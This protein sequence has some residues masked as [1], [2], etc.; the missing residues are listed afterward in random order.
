MFRSSLPLFS[1]GQNQRYRQAAN[2]RHAIHQ[3]H[4][5]LLSIKK[6]IIGLENVIFK[7]HP[8]THPNPTP[9]H[10]IAI[11]TWSCRSDPVCHQTGSQRQAA[12]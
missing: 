7:S 1:A 9:R 11:K 12:L 8:T 3:S 5:L 6:S 10:E 4:S 2:A